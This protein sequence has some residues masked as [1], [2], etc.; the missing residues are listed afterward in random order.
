MQNL[1]EKILIDQPKYRLKQIFKAWFDTNLNSYQEITTLPVGLREQMKNIPWLSL[2]LH[3]IHKSKIDGTEKALLQL[4]DGNFIETVLMGRENLKEDG[5]AGDRYTIC[6]SSQVGCPMRCVF[7]AT[8]KAGFKRNLTTEEIVDQYR[9]W[10]RRGADISNI[11]VMGQGEPLLNYDNLKKALNLILENTKIGVTKITVST[12]GISEMM[13]RLLKDDDFPEVRWAVS[14]H[15]AIEETRAKIMPSHKP[16]FLN[17]LSEWAV[18]YHKKIPSRTHF[19][20]LEYL[21]LKDINDDEEHL[22]ALKKL[23]A[24]FPRLRI[25]LIPYNN[26]ETDGLE[27]SSVEKIENWHESLM[28]AGF[29]CTIRRSQGQDI[30]AACGQLSNKINK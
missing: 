8:G 22:R 30:A 14:L 28:Q 16:G 13:D 11:V 27:K 24:K 7:C 3:S 18:K 2:E 9:F 5:E 29:V 4:A 25:N 12:C 23:A 19:I 6:I 1:L 10:Q 15:S 26:S 21:M 20:G 17:F